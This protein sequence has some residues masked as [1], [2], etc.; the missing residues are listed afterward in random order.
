[1]EIFFDTE[2]VCFKSLEP[3][4]IGFSSPFEQGGE[5]YFE[6][7]D[8]YDATSKSDSDLDFLKKEVLSQ[9]RYDLTEDL[10]KRGVVCGR[11]QMHLLQDQVYKFL[12][13]ARNFSKNG[14]IVLVSDY[15]GDFTVL[16][17]ILPFE[18]QKELNIKYAFPAI[19]LGQGSQMRKEDFLELFNK[20]PFEG[21]KQHHAYLDAWVLGNSFKKAF[22]RAAY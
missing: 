10:S 5:G 15:A 7:T 17:K 16:N 1:M 20:H 2:F 6:R 4:S 18:K 14:N 19:L 12:L 13:N 22:L 11:D 8:I 9:M 3:L 21:L